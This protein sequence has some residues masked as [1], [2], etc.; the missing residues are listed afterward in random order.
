MSVDGTDIF[1]C[2]SKQSVG[3]SNEMMLET[4]SK[5]VDCSFIDWQNYVTTKQLLYII[6]P[7]SVNPK[8]YICS[9]PVGVKK[10]PCK[11]SVYV[12][13]YVK[14]FIVNPYDVT[15]VQPKRKKG[16]PKLARGALSFE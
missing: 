10:R 3:I 8:F 14:N 16:R 5:I 15:P 12:M 2:S 9:C 1:L 4:Y 11:H 6:R 7:S 13:N